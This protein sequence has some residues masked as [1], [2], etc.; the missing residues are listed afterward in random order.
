[1][2]KFRVV[3][4]FA[5]EGP[6]ELS[7]AANDLVIAKS[8]QDADGWLQVK[9]LRGGPQ[10]EGFVPFAYLEF[11]NVQTTLTP[12]ASKPAMAAQAPVAP[13]GDYGAPMMMGM[14]A[15]GAPPPQ[16]Q[17]LAAPG[18]AGGYSSAANPFEFGGMQQSLPPA[19]FKAQQAPPQQQQQQQQPSQL[20][21][22][23]PTLQQQLQQQQQKKATGAAGAARPAAPGERGARHS[24]AAGT[25][26]P[27]SAAGAGRD[28]YSVIDQS[29]FQETLELWRER[30]RRFMKGEPER[31]PQPKRR[32][33]F[34]WDRNGNR[35]GPLFEEEMR[36]R[37]ET[38]QL[39]GD[40]PIQLSVDDRLLDP[41]A[42]R[43]AFPDAQTAFETAPML[44]SR[45]GASPAEQLWCYRD[46]VGNVQGPFPGAKMR[47]WFQEGYF[48]AETQVRL[49]EQG[50]DEFV[51]LGMLFPEGEGA[52]LSPGDQVGARAK[53]SALNDQAR[54]MEPVLASDGAM[55][56]QDLSEFQQ[57]PPPFDPNSP[58]SPFGGAAPM[59]GSNPYMAGVALGGSNPFGNDF[60]AA[61]AA[62]NNPYLA[63]PPAAWGAADPSSNPYLM[64]PPPPL[65]LGQDGGSGRGLYM[66]ALG[67][68]PPALGAGV[69][70]PP[71]ALVPQREDDWGITWDDEPEE[72]AVAQSQ[73]EADAE[74]AVP[75]AIAG[76]AGDDED[77]AP[78][79]TQFTELEQKYLSSVDALYVFLTRSLPK[80]LGTV[81]CKIKRSVVGRLHVNYNLYE[82]YL[83]REDG[84]LGPQILIAQ[85][86]RKYAVDS[87]YNIGIGSVNKKESGKVISSLEFNTMGTHF[88]CHNNVSAHKGKP[89]D[90]C[91]VVYQRG[92]GKGP[93][94][95][96]VAIP[97]LR[98]GSETEQVEWPHGGGSVKKSKM[99]QSLI[100][101]DFPNLQPLVNKK[102]TWSKTHRSWTLNFHG[103][104]TR[105]S[106]KNFQLV[107]PDDNKNTI[108]Q[109]CLPRCLRAR[110]TH[111]H[112]RTHARTHAHELTRPFLLLLFYSLRLALD[113]RRL[114]SSD[115]WARTRL[116]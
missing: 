85:K 83:E 53:M 102:P 8:N 10:A 41:V 97:A 112:A 46:D 82:L 1:M 73:S 25:P 24:Y 19:A 64:N 96:Q 32:V 95:F 74:S 75:M 67:S 36:Q 49:A 65:G 99:L 91:C 56:M 37:L 105:S 18:A 90:L 88:V 22:P 79:V 58:F 104:V 27:S 45:A 114:H 71:P 94:K 60:G 5:A 101:L 110:G 29:R 69:G 34:Y 54:A 6:G 50:D 14:G 106:V 11:L 98:E 3:Q 33:Y 28:Q 116:R 115:A 2:F 72:R 109:V 92:I 51:Q 89:R 93:R 52:F 30:E 44:A 31:L 9:S 84:S 17:Y 23:Q 21:Q 20:Q 15:L 87:Y 40:T 62:S 43:Q 77:E 7:V 12:T 111:A 16:S 107:R 76:P 26:V 48:N 59:D 80:H 39:S 4:S 66:S 78:M 103:R 13:A 63:P 55:Y 100:S 70:A 35:V 113:R 42:L 61:A 38:Q 81:R 108:L 47:D 57:S 68:P 86:L